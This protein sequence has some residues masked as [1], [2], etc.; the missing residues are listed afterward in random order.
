MKSST[1]PIDV[2]LLLVNFGP[3]ELQMLS[4]RECYYLAS[5]NDDDD[6]ELPPEVE[7]GGD[8]EEWSPDA[9]KERLIEALR[10][11]LPER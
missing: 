1:L 11:S 4:E 2:A 8:T 7:P 10:H 5:L 3:E 6:D 9:W